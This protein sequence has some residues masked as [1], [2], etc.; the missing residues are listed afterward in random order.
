MYDNY[1]KEELIKNCKEICKKIINYFNKNT[2]NK[3]YEF[4]DELL[5]KIKC[6]LLENKINIEFT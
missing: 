6:E 2:E 5:G 4:E 3:I 1:L